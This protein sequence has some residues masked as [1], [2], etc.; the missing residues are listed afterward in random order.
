MLV[1]TF[2]GLAVTDLMQGHFQFLVDFGFTSQMEEE[3]DKIASG[4]QEYIPYL[5][6]FY[7]GS[8]GLRSKVEN[9]D[10]KIDPEKARSIKFQHISNL[11]IR[12]G[13]YGAYFQFTDPESGEITKASVPE[14]MAPA[15]LTVESVDKIVEQVKAGPI[16]LATDPETDKKIYLRTGSYGP[17]LQLGDVPDEEG[18]KL[19]R[20]SIPKTIEPDTI[21]ADMAIKLINL[22]RTLGEHPETG[23]PIIT[24]TGRFGPYIMHDG[25]FRS[26]KKEDS[27]LT[28]DYTRAMEILAMP[29]RSR[30]KGTALRDL[31]PHPTT[32]EKVEIFDG[33]YGPYFKVGKANIA[34][35]K[36]MDPEKVTLA[37]ALVV[38]N[39]KMPEGKAAAKAAKAAKKKAV[40][41]KAKKK[42]AK[43]K[44]AKKAGKKTAKK[45]A[46]K[47][48]KKSTKDADAGEA[49]PI[50]SDSSA[51]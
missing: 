24:N 32:K 16:S 29:K 35:G 21:D 38:V 31:G 47:L 48:A 7:L 50:Q 13:K 39:A 23:K 33:P 27:I 9:E 1:P 28:V 37:E 45:A 43:K 18:G 25:D 26:L 14:D 36:D 42:T 41:K 3:L 22:P 15:D 20:V 49:P 6:K 2:T 44:T 12:I 5:R 40:K 4:E 51:E 8:D 11:D 19:K 46:K 17:Y 34:M 30:R 10:D